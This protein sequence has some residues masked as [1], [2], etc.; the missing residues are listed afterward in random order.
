MG[1]FK[2]MKD[3]VR[4]TAK[5]VDVSGGLQGT[6]AHIRLIVTAEG[7]PPTPVDYGT[8]GHPGQ[9]PSEGD[10]IPVTVDRAN[11]LQFTIE[12]SE[13]PS[14]EDVH[15]KEV[16]EREHDMLAEMQGGSQPSAGGQSEAAQLRRE[17]DEDIEDAR[18]IWRENLEQGFCTQEEFDNE[19]RELDQ[20]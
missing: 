3:P 12:W 14:F 11:P 2:R 15:A 6:K 1:L 18:Q 4:G 13:I 5:V 16:A 9:R 19:M 20:A 17:A 8:W 10:S 7:V